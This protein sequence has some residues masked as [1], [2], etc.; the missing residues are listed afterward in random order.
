[1]LTHCWTAL[2]GELQLS[3]SVKLWTLNFKGTYQA[4]MLKAAA[5]AAE[6]GDRT[7]KN[8]LHGYRF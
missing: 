4:V 5:T 3:E 2:N 8:P 6:V 1:L 7:K